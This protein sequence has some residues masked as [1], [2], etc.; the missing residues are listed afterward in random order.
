MN[1]TENP[2][3]IGTG[4]VALDVVVTGKLM[5]DGQFLAG[6]SCGN[7]LTILSYLGWTSY[8]IARLSNNVA[9]ELLLED[10]ARWNIRDDLISVS[11]SGSTPVIIHRI[12]TD[13]LGTPRHRFEFKNPENGKYLPAYKP[14]L[15][16][17]ASQTFATK[18]HTDVF[19]FDRMNRGAIDLA[20]LYKANN[21][22]IFFEPS[23]MKD[24]KAFDECIH[25]SDVVKFSDERISDFDLMYPTAVAGLEIMTMGKSGLKYRL[26]GE[27][28]WKEVL[29]YK[30]DN[31]VDAAGAGDWCTAAIINTLFRNKKLIESTKEEIEYSLR[32]GQA[33]SALNCTFEG[34]RGLMYYLR[35]SDLLVYIQHFVDSNATKIG[36]KKSADPVK[37]AS[38]Q[39]SISS[40][41]KKTN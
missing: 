24:L 1:L 21:A 20:K 7:V 28:F 25:L 40:L 27:S 9:T 8:P 30:V 38:S 14:A 13:K 3:C 41:F 16:K 18:P 29:G 5:N 31:V 34:A 22:S 19:Y 36:Q 17:E 26:K 39:I 12:I 10:M 15:A 4:L 37:K 23:S 35:R 33:L 11:D 2:T 6:G 32:F